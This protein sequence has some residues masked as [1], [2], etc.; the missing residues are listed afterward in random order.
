MTLRLRHLR[1]RVRTTAGLF[2]ADIPFSN[3]LTVLWA[4]NTRGKSTCVQSI[5]YALGLERMLSSQRDIPLPYAM[6]DYL[7]EGEPGNEVEH[8]VIA[9][10]VSLEIE[11]DRGEYAR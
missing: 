8:Q 1:L 5:I 7:K 9:S 3:G 2:G 6:T 10:T 11:N 4:D